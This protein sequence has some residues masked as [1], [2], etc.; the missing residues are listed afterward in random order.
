MRKMKRVVKVIFVVIVAVLMLLLIIC[1]N[2]Q[3]H[4]KMEKELRLPLGQMVEV[5]GNNMSIYVEGTG[6]TT[7]VFMS[8]GG[9]CSPILDFKSLYSLLS[10]KYQIVVVE[11]FGYG[12]SDV[13][14]KK[15]GIE[16]I[17]A[18]TRAA[19]KAAGI[20][21]P[22]ILCPHSMSGIEALYWAQQYPEEVLAIIGLDMV[23]PKSYQDYSINMTMLKLSQFASAIGITRL[24][25][26]VSDSD[27][28]INGTLSNKEK[29]IYRAVFYNRTAT[30]TML[31]EVKSI[32]ENASKVESDNMPQI[33]MLLFVSNGDG[34][35]WDKETWR[36]YQREYI[37]NIANSK[38]IELDC[39]HYVHDYE[40]KAISESIIA[41]LLE[42]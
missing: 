32:K 17:L 10:N 42:R 6:D 19:L 26:G 34:T 8:G 1:I 29:E 23:V 27:A 28:I 2:H 7:L 38:I 5:D 25:P 24:L 14:D 16:S 31:N 4:L 3:I 41:F 9:T 20:E 35:S 18:D 22:Y 36:S 39:P 11:K 12:F 30:I 13:V 15:R 40:Y 37:A 33:P 21:A